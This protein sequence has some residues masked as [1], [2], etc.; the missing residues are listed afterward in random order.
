MRL[1]IAYVG[2]TGIDLSRA[3]QLNTKIIVPQQSLLELRQLY[4]QFGSIVSQESSGRSR[5]DALQLRVTRRFSGLMFDG[6][7]VFSKALD[8]GSGPLT[9]SRN[10][11]LLWARSAFDRRHN[12][13]MSYAYDLPAPRAAG[14][15]GQ[16]AGGWQVSGISEFRSGLPMD[17]SQ[18]FDSTLTGRSLFSRPD[19]VGPYLRFD[20][21]RQQTIVINGVQQTGHFFFDPRA[22]QPVYV[23][24]AADARPGDL[25]RNV[26]DGPGLALWSLSVSKQIRLACSQQLNLRADI[27]N[28]FNHANFQTPGLQAD[29]G[30]SFGQV[31]LAAPGRTVQ[32]SLTYSV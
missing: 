9:D 12:L 4:P 18:S 24:R 21:R 28:L 30:S 6:S 5:Y 11:P 17:I 32:L 27:R 26:F 2:T 22:F 15:I 13:V 16:L 20:P 1:E 23:R 25:G 10:D 29:V 3:R 7:Y 31:S 19:F 8:N 14:V